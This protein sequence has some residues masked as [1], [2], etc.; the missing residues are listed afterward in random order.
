MANTFRNDVYRSAKS[1]SYIVTALFAGIALSAVF[2][3]VISVVWKRFSKFVS[4][5]QFAP[6]PPFYQ[7]D[8]T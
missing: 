1:L 8:Q 7:N 3:I 6:P 5:G 2:N 4:T